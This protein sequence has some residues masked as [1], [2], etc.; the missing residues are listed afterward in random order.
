MSAL[1]HDAHDEEKRAGRDPVVQLLHDTSSDPH[2]RQREHTEH[3]QTHVAD[4]RVRDQPFPITLGH[5][6]QRTVNDADDRERGHER[7]ERLC[8]LRQD[9][10]AEPDETVRPHLQEYGRQDDRPGGR[11][12]GM[13]VR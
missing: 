4:T 3:Y 8:R 13:S 2:R 6:Y 7:H 12:V 5:R 11:R 9:G 1:V 10:E